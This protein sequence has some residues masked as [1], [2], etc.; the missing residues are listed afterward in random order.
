MKTETRYQ[1][2]INH[3]T[4]WGDIEHIEF[5]DSVQEFK[6][7]LKSIEAGEYDSDFDAFSFE[8]Q[9]RCYCDYLGDYET[10]HA[11]IDEDGIESKFCNGDR[12]PK[13]FIK[14]FS[15]A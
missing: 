4:H 14:S 3:E 8:L 15:A 6:N 7:A 11:V 1:L 13:R 10:S 2:R 5:F 9:K 12:V